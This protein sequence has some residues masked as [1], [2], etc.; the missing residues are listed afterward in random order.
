MDRIGGT[1]PI[2]VRT[3]GVATPYDPFAANAAA[4]DLRKRCAKF[5]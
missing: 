1:L 3:E 4:D 2:N 5:V